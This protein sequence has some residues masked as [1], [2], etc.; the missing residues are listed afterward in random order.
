MKKKKLN[1]N[2]T[3]PRINAFIELISNIMEAYTTCLFLASED[4][5]ESVTL[6]SSYS[7][8]NNIKKKCTIKKGEGII[9]WVLREQKSV[10]ATYF[11]KRDATTL[12]F[13]DKNEEIK[14]FLAIPLPVKNGILCVD[15]KKSYIF[16]EEKEK[17]LIQMSDILVSIIYSEQEIIEK[18]II[19]SLLSLSLDFDEIIIKTK[20]KKL[21]IK[22]FFY[23]LINKL[24]LYIG[25]FLIEDELINI[26]YCQ[27]KN[28]IFKNIIYDKEIDNSGFVNWI[29]NNNKELFIEKT[30]KGNNFFVLNKNSKLEFDNFLGFP[31][32][33]KNNKKGV[34]LYIKKSND[35]WTFKEKNTLKVLSNLFYKEYLSKK[36]HV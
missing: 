27:N 24:D 15:S 32:N 14:S 20:I 22:D 36:D 23:L 2:K 33:D 6:F 34:L 8:S 12:K 30:D 1:L 25:I 21:F 17:I 29:I 16:T 11:D 9:G 5:R 13:Y 18:N 28:I 3:T 7:L 26:G 10:V 31:I 4:D 35:I 19:N